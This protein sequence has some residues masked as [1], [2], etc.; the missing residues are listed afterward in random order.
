MQMSRTRTDHLCCLG[1][2]TD[3]LVTPTYKTPAAAWL[4]YQFFPDGLR[5][6]TGNIYTFFA[7]AQAE[8]S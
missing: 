8:V 6:T 4:G 2:A 3:A 7:L 5:Y 1:A